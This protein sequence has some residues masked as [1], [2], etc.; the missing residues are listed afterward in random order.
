MSAVRKLLLTLVVV[1]F[2]L[3]GPRPTEAGPRCSTPSCSATNNPCPSYCQPLGWPYGL[4]NLQT[5]C[6]VCSD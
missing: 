5:H 6:C 1:G 2:A 3:S 4:C